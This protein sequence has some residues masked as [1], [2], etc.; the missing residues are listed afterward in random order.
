MHLPI[1][2]LLLHR[3]YDKKI[4]MTTKAYSYIYQN[5][6]EMLDFIPESCMKILEVGCGDGSFSVQLKE[7]K[8]TEVW[9][10]EMHQESAAIASTK[11]D[12][13]ICDNFLQLLE[14]EQLPSIYFDCIVFNDVLEHFP[15][16]NLILNKIKKYLAPEAFV[17]TSLPN[18]R[19]VGNLWEI[20]I[21]KDF[22]Y[23]SSGILDYTHYRFFTLKS[24]NRMFAEQ[25][26]TVIRTTGINPTKSVKVKLLNLFTFNFFADIPFLQIATLAQ[27]KL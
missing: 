9:G 15:D 16:Y 6:S 10:I 2:F 3:F 5:R 20:L 8:G 13:V 25:G 7:R 26:Y 23:K 27:F 18:F 21:S 17:I 24:I 14:S 1:P 19:Y 4:P 12:K 22:K 11:L